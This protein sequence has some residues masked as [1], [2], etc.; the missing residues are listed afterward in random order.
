[1]AGLTDDE[2]QKLYTW[3]D[4]IPLSRPKRNI[5]RDFA[6]CVLVAEVISHYFPKIVQLHNYSAANS[7]PQK[8][9]NWNTLNGKVLRKLGWQISKE[10]IENI[11]MSKPGSIER[12]LHQLQ[13]KMAKYRANGGVA[14]APGPAP[15]RN[16]YS[17]QQQQ[18]QQRR[19]VSSVPP[20]PPMNHNSNFPP[21]TPVSYN[22]LD[23]QMVGRRQPMPQQAGNSGYDRDALQRE[24][25]EE[26]LL[27]K[28]QTIQEL[29]DTVE[30][31]E[32][33]ISKLEQLVRLKDSK[34]SKLQGQMAQQEGFD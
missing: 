32:L 24:V 19:N 14:K 30:I 12:F 20:N 28:E 18:Q 4:E 26:I 34:I 10:D 21:E 5:G 29:R 6:D 17:Q 11:I 3:I 8:L 33:K 22:N 13:F 2:L 16:K 9:Y 23:N 7:T 25:D 31:L 27:E 1:M 15:V